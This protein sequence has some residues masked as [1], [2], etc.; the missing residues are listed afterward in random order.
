MKGKL[1]A[2][3]QPYVLGDKEGFK[4]AAVS[5]ANR[6]AGVAFGEAMLHTIGC[7]LYPIPCFLCPQ[8]CCLPYA[9][10]LAISAVG[11]LLRCPVSDVPSA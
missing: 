3:L 5:E 1:A 8:R 11:P 7:A 4:A 10:P 6:L 9:L 2:R